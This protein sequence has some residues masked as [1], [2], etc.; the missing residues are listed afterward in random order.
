MFVDDDAG[1][2]EPI[3]LLSDIDVD[4][5]ARVSNGE[6]GVFNDH[7]VGNFLEMDPHVLEVRHWFIEVVVDDI[8]GNVSVPFAGIG[9][10]GVEVDLEVHLD[11]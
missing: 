5:A 8:C 3:H 1:F 2:L 7:L 9:D 10:D 4:I 11:D 6:E